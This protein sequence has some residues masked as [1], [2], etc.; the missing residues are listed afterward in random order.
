MARCRR[1][2]PGEPGAGGWREAD[3]DDP[4]LRHQPSGDGDRVGGPGARPLGIENSL[5]R[6][7]DVAFREDESRAR[8]GHAGAN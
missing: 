4:L 5:H 7:L 6:V 1:R 8:A 3:P 2:R